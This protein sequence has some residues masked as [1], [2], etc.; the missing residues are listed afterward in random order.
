M[1]YLSINFGQNSFFIK[2][3]LITEST[4]SVEILILI[5]HSIHLQGRVHDVFFNLRKLNLNLK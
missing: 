4:L 3:L 2:T 1:D 5:R